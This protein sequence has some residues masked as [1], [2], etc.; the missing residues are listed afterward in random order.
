VPQRILGDQARQ[1]LGGRRARGQQLEGSRT[2]CH[3]DVGLGGDGADGRPRPGDARADR[4]PV[5]LDRDAEFP[6]VRIAAT[7]E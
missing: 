6:G 5:R 3:L 4:E 1:R 7:I 2:V